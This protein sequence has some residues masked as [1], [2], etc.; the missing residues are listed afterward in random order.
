MNNTDLKFKTVTAKDIDIIRTTALC[1]KINKEKAADILKDAYEKNDNDTYIK[2]SYALFNL[3][4]NTSNDALESKMKVE[5]A[6]FAFEEILEDKPD[7][8]LAWLYKIRILMMLPNNNKDE[9]V[10]IDELRD[11]IQIQENSDY[12]PYFIAPYFLLAELY[13]NASEI[14]KALDIIEQA[15]KLQKCKISNFAST[16]HSIFKSFIKKAAVMHYQDLMQ[17][18][19]HLEH[20]F[21]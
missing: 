13:M 1:A 6:L 4:A 16:I 14:P 19:E 8:W 21:F 3:C 20:A 9:S 10:I 11:M 7:Y 18:A 2:L 15:E 12:M 5:A 17:R